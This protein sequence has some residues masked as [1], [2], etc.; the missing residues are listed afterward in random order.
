MEIKQLIDLYEKRKSEK[1]HKLLNLLNGS[2]SFMVMQSMPGE[3][4]GR[5]NTVE[6]VFQNNLKYFERLIA[7]QYSDD[8]PENVRD[9]LTG[10]GIVAKVRMGVDMKKNADIL[11]RVAHPDL[12]LIVQIDFDEANAAKNYQELYDILEKLYA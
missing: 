2:G 6:E 10:T 3:L 8:V 1:S 4:W 9:S 5:C 7:F 12:P 11:Q